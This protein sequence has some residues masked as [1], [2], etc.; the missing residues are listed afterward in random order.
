MKENKINFK[1]KLKNI[2]IKKN[3][4]SKLYLDNEKLK[5]DNRIKKRAK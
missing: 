4:I 5:S 2:I 3:N 1:T